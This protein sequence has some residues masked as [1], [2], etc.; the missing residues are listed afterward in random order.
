MVLVARNYYRFIQSAICH[1]VHALHQA[2]GIL[3]LEARVS[4]ELTL[5]RVAFLGGKA[6]LAIVPSSWWWTKNII[7]TSATRQRYRRNE[8]LIAPVV[9]RRAKGSSSRASRRSAAKE[10]RAE[11]YRAHLK[12]HSGFPDAFPS[13]S[14]T[15]G[16]FS[17]GYPLIWRS[18]HRP[19]S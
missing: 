11:H 13:G 12:H 10:S 16:C 4:F 18:N 14:A 5:Q 1:T 9:E 17:L 19:G 8:A 3:C 6:D 7:I 2:R 15:A